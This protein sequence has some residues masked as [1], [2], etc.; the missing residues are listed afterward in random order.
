MA[1]NLILYL[2]VYIIMLLIL[3]TVLKDWETNPQ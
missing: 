3:N 1:I 2:K